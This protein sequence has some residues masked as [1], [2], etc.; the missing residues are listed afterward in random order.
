[1]DREKNQ[2][3]GKSDLRIGVGENL[4]VVLGEVL[5]GGVGYLVDHLSHSKKSLEC[6]VVLP[7]GVW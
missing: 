7:D 3:C 6:R 5:C 2:T 4:G 1:M